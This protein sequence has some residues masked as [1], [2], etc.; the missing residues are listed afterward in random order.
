ML[1]QM[2]KIGLKNDRKN[3]FEKKIVLPRLNMTQNEK[4][5]CYIFNEIGIEDAGEIISINSPFKRKIKQTNQ[6]KLDLQLWNYQNLL[7]MKRKLKNTT[8]I[9]RK[10]FYA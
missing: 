4:K 1:P 8:L 9:L 2:A 3:P 10:H 6:Y 5:N 7:P